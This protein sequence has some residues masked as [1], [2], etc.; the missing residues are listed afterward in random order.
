MLV[1]V[2]RWQISLFWPVQ[3]NHL[4]IAHQIIPPSG[5]EHFHGKKQQEIP[6]KQVLVRTVEILFYL[7][8]VSNAIAVNFDIIAVLYY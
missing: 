4:L 3:S 8:L 2:P 1:S 6:R 7:V 5:R